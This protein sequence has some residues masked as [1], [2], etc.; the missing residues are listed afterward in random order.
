[1]K[2]LEEEEE[3]PGKYNPSK[4]RDEHEIGQNIA[5]MK[6]TN[7]KVKQCSNKCQTKIVKFMC[8]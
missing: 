7:K 8:L 3:E 2:G 6:T 4:E 5:I 1:L